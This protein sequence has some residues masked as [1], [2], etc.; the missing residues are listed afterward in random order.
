MKT[1]ITGF[2]LALAATFA[3]AAEDPLFVR[4]T[5]KADGRV[6]DQPSFLAAVGQPAT[7]SLT[8]G[9][10]VEAL[11]K[12]AEA[13]GGS[14]TQVRITYSETRDGKFVHEMSLHHSP[15]LRSGSF[16]YTDPFNRRFTIQVGPAK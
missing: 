13:D 11:A 14:W 7:V 9:G 2:L 16:D 1:G 12:P 8:S 4:V 5:V 15:G 6:V 10:S 3:V